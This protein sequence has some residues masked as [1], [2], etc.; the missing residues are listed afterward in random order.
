[1]LDH[2]DEY[3]RAPDTPPVVRVGL[4]LAD[5][6]PGG[7]PVA[8]A[9][10]RAGIE[11]MARQF[12]GGEHEREAV[13]RV[14]AL[15]RQGFAA[16]VDLLGEKTLTLGDADAYAR[17]VAA[18]FGALG[19]A[20][21][22]L[23]SRALLDRD[24]WGVL[25][26]VN[27]SIKASALAPLL[28][29]ATIDE[30]MAEAME[31]LGPIVE[32]AV[33]DGATVHLD[34]EHD[35]LK[36]PTFALLREV[37]RRWPAAHLGCVVQAYRVD[38]ARDL[39]ELMRWSATT[40]EHPLQVRLVKGAYWDVETMKAQA[41]GWRPPVWQDKDATDANYEALTATLVARAGDVRPAFA[42]HNA[43]SIA[44]AL[45]AAAEAGLPRDAVEIQVLHGMAQPLHDAVRDQSVR[46]RV[47]VPIGELVPGMAYLV[48]RLLENT[49]NESFVRQRFTDHGAVDDLVAPPRPREQPNQPV[50]VPPGDGIR[51]AMT[52]EPG[53]APFDN[54]PHAELRRR[55]VQQRLV[56]TVD[57]V[58]ATLGF[59]V[60]LRIGGAARETPRTIVSVDPSRTEVIV[61]RSASATTADAGDAVAVASRAFTE[62]SRTSWA[63]RAQVLFDAAAIM[64]HRRDELCALEVLEAGKPIAEADADVCEAIDFCEYYGRDALRIAEGAPALDKPGEDNRYWY[65]PRGVGVVIAPWNFPLAL[66][67][68]MVTAALVTGNTVVLKPAE[69][70]PAVA[71]QLVEILFA[72][73]LAPEALAFL[74]GVGEAVGPALVEHPD[75]AFVT[76]TGSKAVGLD[77]VRRAGVVQPGQRHVKRVVAE[78][79]GKNAVVVDA[80]ADLDDTVPAIIQGAFGYAGQKCSATSRVIVCEHVADALE[81]RLAGATEL[82]P[83]GP[84]RDPAT[85]VGPLIDADAL[86]RVHAYQARAAHEGRVL[87]QRTDLPSCGWFA[88]PTLVALASP[89]SSIARDEIFGPVLAVL[90]APDFDAALAMA[91]DTDY[92]LTAGCFSRTPSHLERAARELRAGNVYL[93]RSTTGAMV[94]RQPFGGVGLSGVGSKAGGPDYLAQFVEPR[95]VSENTVR[96]GFAPDRTDNDPNRRH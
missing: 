91:N 34:T 4:Q 43:R 87:V 73:G 32:R 71:A 86:T 96:H 20:A 30:G 61:C 38:A 23:A 45:C 49:A 5:G 46:T 64:R 66:P 37:G 79:G 15:R 58:D 57:E 10:A 89:A 28:A 54:E 13:A 94:G 36:D 62:W 39:D 27:V 78:M 40:L 93:N 80:D 25:P 68:G 90:R 51:R 85:V 69:Q 74:P 24:P 83:V 84:A 65:E 88:G 31:R 55:E 75:V 41:M 14:E 53:V 59:D 63:E 33:V 82:V 11:R 18:M 67:T 3:L 2:L 92:A 29:P 16:T 12:I 35:E 1:V 42:T 50:S 44:F 52:P 56:A 70:A 26:R 7:A 60:P 47:Y 6:V 8:R 19:A 21:P 81:A 72:A 95:S 76:F 9:A 77:I 17:R 48:R 22:R